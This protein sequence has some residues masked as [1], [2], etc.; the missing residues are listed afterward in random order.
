MTC[1]GPLEISPRM[2][3]AVD[4]LRRLIRTH[5]PDAQFS[6]RPSPDDANVVHLIAV[7]DTEN[8]DDVLDGVVD[9]MMEIQIEESLPVY[10]VPVRPLRQQTQNTGPPDVDQPGHSVHGHALIE[11]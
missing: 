2:E 3:T 8:L 7:V 5:Y 6:V 11:E 4:E 10:V 1:E 9:R